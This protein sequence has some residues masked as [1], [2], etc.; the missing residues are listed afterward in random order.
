MAGI[1][2]LPIFQITYQ[3][4]GDFRS[5]QFQLCKFQ[6]SRVVTGCSAAQTDIPCGVIQNNPNSGEAAVV[7]HAG[8]SKVKAGESITYGNLIGTT[9]TGAVQALTAGSETTK[10]IIGMAVES[11][12]SGDLCAALINCINPCRAA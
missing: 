1:T 5:S 9:S 11:V 4:F 3:A 10:Y 12:D 7:M 6:A 2:Q 8:L